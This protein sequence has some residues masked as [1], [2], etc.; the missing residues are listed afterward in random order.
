MKKIV[1]FDID[2]TLL[3][4]NKELPASTVQAIQKLKTSGVYVAIATGRAPFMFENLRKKLGID[5]FVSFNGQ[6]VVFED[7]VIYKNPLHRSKLHE[8]K[9]RAHENGHPLVFM[10][11][12]RMRASVEEHPYIHVSMESLKFSHPPFDP[13][14]YEQRDIY[15][16]LLFCKP[17]EEH[18]YIT[19]YPE[20]H[21]VRWHNVSTDVLPFGGS[22][23]EGIRRL[24][25]RV[26]IDK[27]D[28]YAF[29]DGLNDI[30]MLQFVGT[31]VAMG[32]ANEKVKE[33]A[34]FVTKRVDEEGILYGLKQLELIK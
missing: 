33:V 6:Y 19:S 4:E 31:G 22:K 7:E 11:A 5:S 15:Q 14:Y 30:E 25:E 9:E 10:D 29:G 32:N 2:G 17:E 28:V 13:L 3:D 1:F 20:F 34:N 26:G 24:I 21:F 27:E 18:V 16:A 12:E 23:A 8:L